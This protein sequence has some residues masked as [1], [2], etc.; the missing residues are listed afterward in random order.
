MLD[1]N[2]IKS[3]L[4]RHQEKLVSGERYLALTQAR[5]EKRRVIIARLQAKLASATTIQTSS[6]P[7][8]KKAGAKKPVKTEKIKLAFKKS[9]TK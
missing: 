8:E 4:K 3:D 6:K 2:D 7:V 9:S 1:T 5:V